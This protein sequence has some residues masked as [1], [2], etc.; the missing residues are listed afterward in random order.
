MHRLEVR[1]TD[2]QIEVYFQPIGGQ[3]LTQI[4]VDTV[5]RLSKE[6]GDFQ[7]ISANVIRGVHHLAAALVHTARGLD[8]GSAKA[9]DRGIELM[10]WLSGE[11]QIRKALDTAGLRPGLEGAW[12]I[13]FDEADD[14][15]LPQILDLTAW[16]ELEDNRIS[17]A[18]G[19]A[20]LEKTALT[21]WDDR[22]S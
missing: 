7:L 9:R 15:L 14:Q 4:Q 10:R 6:R 21:D 17:S 22:S 19:L 16:S 5:I 12:L 11:R 2:T 3:P 8:D 18:E 13:K 1:R 20:L